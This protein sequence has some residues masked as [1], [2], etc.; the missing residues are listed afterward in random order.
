MSTNE[1][2]PFR[3]LPYGTKFR[4]Q[5]APDVWVRTQHNVIAEWPCRIWSADGSPRSS[6]CCFCHLDG[7]EDGNTLDTLVEVVDAESQ[8][9]ALREELAKAIKDRETLLKLHV[10]LRARRSYWITEE[11]KAQQ[12]LAD[13]EL[14]NAVMAALLEEHQ[15]EWEPYDSHNHRPGG[16]YCVECGEPKESSHADKCEIAAALNK[17]EEDNLRKEDDEALQRRHDQ[18][19]ADY[20]NSID[21]EAKSLDPSIIGIER[22]PPMEYDEP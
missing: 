19:R 12:R 7:D 4:Y 6:L 22:M 3:L 10:H 2:K 8:L 16:Y 15:W 14:L 1:L 5:G 9:A 17:P 18:E 20:F 13:A 21:E 11:G